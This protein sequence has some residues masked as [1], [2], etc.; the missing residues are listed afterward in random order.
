[1]FYMENKEEVPKTTKDIAASLRSV[2]GNNVRDMREEI[3]RQRLSEG[4]KKFTQE[5][6]ARELAQSGYSVQSGQIGH[7]ENATKF[8]SIP[9][10]VALADFFGTSLDFIVGRTKNLSSI[11]AIDEDL[12]TGG[13]SGRLGDIYKK[14]PLERQEEVYRF[15]EALNLIVQT[16]LPQI[17]P[18]PL[19]RRQRRKSAVRALLD[20]IQRE[21]GTAV[22]DEIEEM[23]RSKGIPIDLEP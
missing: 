11:A 16:D 17:A 10:L 8:P 3:S 5:V 19:N 9:L 15:A 1:M 23:L 22:R 20:L 18:L 4:D 6:L 12:Q 7:V 2:I 14:L 21:R 13:I